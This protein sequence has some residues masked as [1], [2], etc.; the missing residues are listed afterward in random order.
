MT[1]A[2]PIV[3]PYSELLAAFAAAEE[4]EGWLARC[5]EAGRYLALSVQFVDA[6]ATALRRLGQ[7]PVVEICAGDAALAAALGSRGLAVT[8][9]DLRPPPRTETQVE[10]LAVDEALRRHRPRVVLASFVP[11][12]TGVDRHV[13]DCPGVQHYVVLNA[14]LGGECGTVCLWTHPGWTRTPLEAVTRWMIC[15]HDVWLG[16]ERPPLTHGEAWLLSRPHLRDDDK[17]LQP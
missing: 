11:V 17:T 16:T 14:R 13:L 2:D 4:A 12:D 3:A 7:S 6:L 9:T 10:P 15:R 1:D 8:A 5:V